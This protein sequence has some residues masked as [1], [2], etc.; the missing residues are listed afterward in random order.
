[1]RLGHDYGRFEVEDME[2]KQVQRRVSVNTDVKQ[3]VISCWI[4][5]F[6]DSS[7]RPTKI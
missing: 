6:M 5:H 1:M 2:E 7:T 3:V 4:H